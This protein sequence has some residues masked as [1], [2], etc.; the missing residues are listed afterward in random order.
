MEIVRDLL[1]ESNQPA[2]RRYEPGRIDVLGTRHT[3]SVILTLS[4]V[5]D[6]WPPQSID[7]LEPAHLERLTELD[8]RPETVLIGTGEQQVF[9]PHDV[10]APLIDA[11]MGFEFMDTRAAC[12]TWNILLAEDRHAVAALMLR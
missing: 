3:A 6:G 9:P 8:P 7:A 2:V 12:R 10:V 5:I 4:D 11:R 1:A